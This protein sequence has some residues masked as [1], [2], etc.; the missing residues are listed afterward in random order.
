M[1]LT[2]GVVYNQGVNFEITNLNQF[3]I[4]GGFAD[5]NFDWNTRDPSV[6]QTRICGVQQQGV[7]TTVNIST[8]SWLLLDGLWIET[9]SNHTRAVNITNSDHVKIR[10]CF[11]P[12]QT[13]QTSNQDQIIAVSEYMAPCSSMVVKNNYFWATGAHAVHL[14]GVSGTWL[15]ENNSIMNCSDVG[16]LLEATASSG[17]IKS[18]TISN[19]SIGIEVEGNYPVT[20]RRNTI[21]TTSNDLDIGILLNSDSSQDTVSFNKIYKAGV[22]GIKTSGPAII[23][24]NG[25]RLSQIGILDEHLSGQVQ[26]LNNSVKNGDGQDNTGIFRNTSVQSTAYNNILHCCYYGLKASSVSNFSYGYNCFYSTINRSGCSAQNGDIETDPIFDDSFPPTSWSY[27]LD[28]NSP[29]IDAGNGDSPYGTVLRSHS[30]DT[31]IIDM[32]AHHPDVCLSN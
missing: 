21:G 28:P 11:F 18:N 3:S 15:V 17:N 10:N 13:G 30:A 4:Y 31:G 22:A 12:S 25:V 19:S 2:E 9:Y 29:C 7:T 23:K 8:N 16:I 14:D 5:S 1:L 32:G 24:S 26:I 20:I 27:Y 6:Y